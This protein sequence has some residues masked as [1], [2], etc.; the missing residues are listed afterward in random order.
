MVA[1]AVSSDMALRHHHGN[2]PKGQRVLTGGVPGTETRG[3]EPVMVLAPALEARIGDCCWCGGRFVDSNMWNLSVTDG[4]DTHEINGVFIHGE[5]D[6]ARADATM[7]ALAR[8][9]GTLS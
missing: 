7:E 9:G 6:E 8:T 3:G 4:D 5:C 1:A 2:D